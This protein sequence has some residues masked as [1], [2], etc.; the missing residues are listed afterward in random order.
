MRECLRLLPSTLT[1][2]K[3]HLML[4]ADSDPRDIAGIFRWDTGLVRDGVFF[5]GYL[6][7]NL[8]DDT[9]FVQTP[10]NQSSTQGIHEGPIVLKQE[11]PD[12]MDLLTSGRTHHIPQSSGV[13]SAEEGVSI[14][15]S[16]IAE[17]QWA[18]SKSD[19][20]EEN[21]RRLWDETQLRRHQQPQFTHSSN[22]IDFSYSQSLQPPTPNSF[23]DHPIY[24]IAESEKGLRSNQPLLSPLTVTLVP[25]RIES[26]PSTAC[27]TD[28][29]S[30]GW[31]SYTPPGTSTS[32]TSAGTTNISSGGSPVFPSL[33]AAGNM[34]SGFKAEVQDAF[35]QDLDQFSFDAGVGYEQQARIS[36][37]HPAS[38]GPSTPSYLDYPPGPGSTSSV[39]GADDTPHFGKD[40]SSGFYH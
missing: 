32:V 21:I 3:R 8:A 23:L 39:L 6:A 33:A 35:Y 1:T 5:A 12:V 13:S 20:R 25:T 2:I 36:H 4:Q 34:D 16:A 24:G 26:A 9:C 31:P 10:A 11:T 30:S 7:A 40:C 27:S 17:M 14:C 37:H 15:L 19:E 38:G 22:T 18:F 29:S 28:G